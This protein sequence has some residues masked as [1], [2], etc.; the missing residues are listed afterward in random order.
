MKLMKIAGTVILVLVLVVGIAAFFLFQNLEGLAK[1]GI[2]NLGSQVT[3]TD[4]RV[5]GVSLAL[6]Q[7]RGELSALSVGNPDGF[8]NNPLLEI[9]TV[10]LQI[11]P[12]SVRE[13]VLV[14]EEVVIDGA[15]LRL[16]HQR[17][18]D[19][20]IKQLVDNI[21]ASV[22]TQDPEVRDDTGTEQLFMVSRLRFTNISMD[23]V[24]S[25]IEDRTVALGDIE[26]RDLGSR[27]QGLTGKQLA[28]AIA[29]PLI[30]EAR[31]KFEA[32]ARGRAEGLLK[33]AI[34]E[35]LSDEDRNK[36]DRLRSRFR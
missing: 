22:G 9:Q 23:I 19:T 31:D 33:E 15:R 21:R 32:E 18:L 17:A 13:E 35:Q 14:L 3:Q 16:E 24:S 11:A 30:D 36:L 34:D 26:R 28:L 1:R 12:A 6:R 7:G 20:N 10:A 2:E 8:S 29:Q 25:Q 5:G 27:E 4:V